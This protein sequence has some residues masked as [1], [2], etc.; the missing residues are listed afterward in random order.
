MKRRRLILNVMIGCM[1]CLGWGGWPA[2]AAVLQ[3]PQ[4]WQLFA[5]EACTA[6][7][8]TRPA[9]AECTF[10]R[11]MNGKYQVW[12]GCTTSATVKVELIA[13]P[14]LTTIRPRTQ[15]SAVLY[16]QAMFGVTT[17][18]GSTAAPPY[19]GICIAPFPYIPY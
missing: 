1:L 18:R 17:E 5:C 12:N 19:P 11:D 9:P 16:D 7:F 15:G 3:C 10:T 14:Q 6:D 2:T 8:S 13:N 4:G